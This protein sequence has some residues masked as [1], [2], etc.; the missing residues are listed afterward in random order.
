MPDMNAESILN[1]ISLAANF[2]PAVNIVMHV[3]VLGAIVMLFTGAGPKLRRLIFDAV[4]LILAAAVA[5]ISILVGNPFNM[6][7]FGIIAVISLI[8]LIRG[9]NLAGRPGLNLN[10]V[11]SLII[12]FIG[13]WY[14][15]FVQ[16]GLPAMLVLSPLGVIPCPTLMVMLGMLNLAV[17]NVN[18]VQYIALI[19]M[20]AFYGLTGVFMLKVYL[21]IALLV[22]LLYSLYN[23]RLI[24]GRR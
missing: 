7:T 23:L 1:A 12:I 14:P 2:S 17:P 20:A 21:D 9:K 8:E 18:R 22:I 24:F 16:A 13:F 5:V 3:L 4:L 6:L 11:I 15:E 10:T 19:V